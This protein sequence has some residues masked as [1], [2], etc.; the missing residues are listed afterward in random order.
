M[1]PL[2]HRAPGLAG[3]VL[4]TVEVAAELICD[5]FH[6]HRALVRAAIA[7]K[8]PS[9]IMAVSDG[10]AA[11]GLRVG[12]W[13][14]LGGLEVTVGESAAYLRDGTVAGSITTMDRMF[15][16]LVTEMGL[17]L[18]DAVTICSTTPARELGLFGHG[19]LAPEAAADL[20]VLDSNLR[21]VQTYV[22]GQLVYSRAPSSNTSSASISKNL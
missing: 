15:Q 20:V 19:I 6:V 22:A 21:V 5:G 3:A 11:S 7:A 9:R 16:A 10:T 4:Q 2:H 12:A 8:G 14:S 13:T 1:P 17:S 18:I